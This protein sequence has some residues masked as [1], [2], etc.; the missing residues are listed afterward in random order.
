MPDRSSKDYGVS[1]RRSAEKVGAGGVIP[2]STETYVTPS[3]RS[4]AYAGSVGGAYA[5][6]ARRN[7]IDLEQPPTSSNPKPKT[8]VTHQQTIPRAGSPLSRTTYGADTAYVTAGTSSRSSQPKREHKRLY[9]VDD[10]GHSQS[11]HSVRTVT[12]DPYVRNKDSWG[13]DDRRE[14]DSRK[15]KRDHPTDRDRHYHGSSRT[16]ARNIDD[17]YGYT[18]P[19]GMYRDTEPSWRPRHGSTDTRT[20]ERPISVIDTDAGYDY[21]TG[22]RPSRDMGPPPTTRGF[23]RI[24]QGLERGGS[25]RDTREPRG[26]SRERRESSGDPPKFLGVERAA[27]FDMPA[28]PSST[29]PPMENDNRL[30]ADQRYD[31]RD[32]PYDDR[33]YRQSSREPRAPQRQ[34]TDHAVGSRGFG[35]RSGSVDHRS[36]SRDP[37]REGLLIYPGDPLPAVGRDEAPSPDDYLPSHTTN[38]SGR[39]H[40][41]RASDR[42]DFRDRP[43]NRYGDV[44]D[45]YED[46]RLRAQEP[47]G[48]RHGSIQADAHSSRHGS[49]QTDAH[50]SRHGSVQ[51]GLGAAAGAAGLGLGAYAA[52]KSAEDRSRDRRYDDDE[53]DDDRPR[54][55]APHE[56]DR[57]FDER[58]APPPD[59]R[60][61][62]VDRERDS[63][64]ERERDRNR[65]RDRERERERERDRRREQEEAFER[66]ALRE[67]AREPSPD[68]KPLAI[69]DAKPGAEDLDP[70]EEY[71]RR[72][73]QA[74]EQLASVSVPLSRESTREDD[75]RRRDRDLVVEPEHPPAR[76]SREDMAGAL[77]PRSS[78][79][80]LGLAA[81]PAITAAS[82]MPSMN[83]ANWASPPNAPM[84]DMDKDGR[85]D[86]H[87]QRPRQESFF[88]DKPMMEEPSNLSLPPAPSTTHQFDDHSDQQLVPMR[89]RSSSLPS[90]ENR[91]RIVEPPKEEKE[92]PPLKGILKKPKVKF[93]EDPNPE[94]EGVTT[95]K[96]PKR[97]RK[98]R[99]EGIP[100]DARW[101]KIDRSWV[102]PEALKEFGERFEERLDYVI[103]LRVLTKDEIQKYADRTR[104]IRGEQP[105]IPQRHDRRR[106]T[107]SYVPHPLA[108]IAS[109]RTASAPIC[110]L[111]TEHQYAAPSGSSASRCASRE[112]DWDEARMRGRKRS[113][114]WT[115][116]VV[117]CSILLLLLLLKI[118]C[119]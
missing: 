18:T 53:N 74:S 70:D 35:I 32:D 112:P 50:S 99:Q 89:S 6:R 105:Y 36:T 24:S 108:H 17:A 65:D 48:S 83:N 42:T 113:V 34:Y 103:V 106:A 98:A 69:E 91:V 26:S 2:I 64:R 55:R 10:S 86:Y 47:H 97:D 96:D 81:P 5:G 78:K 46:D 49:I 28:R 73:Q 9:S 107:F 11:G 45:A 115:D 101:T 59:R 33:G 57:D 1:E 77:P 44:P 58:P 111:V 87:N 52:K 117:A 29:R 102:N 16:K 118:E 110:R 80:D 60:D 90:K 20:R 40:G 19:A 12:A 88:G 30:P 8:I 119:N 63:D 31:A 95:T 38:D 66:E 43:P 109:S 27:T 94:R 68:D 15:E 56:D 61:R 79:D 93:P 3:S 54:R 82:S 51:S 100:S 76:R 14:S 21:P 7:T 85:D 84:S 75:R 104:Q 72:V 25:V 92:S 22:H 116:G 114:H 62:G 39:Y 37:S 41:R 13:G 71:R 4:S 67:R 23:D